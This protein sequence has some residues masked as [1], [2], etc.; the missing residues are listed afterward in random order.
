MT[1]R[2]LRVVELERRAREVGILA[3][4]HCPRFP[5]RA[6]WLE[7]LD[8]VDL[9]LHAGDLVDPGVLRDL[10]ALAPVV[11]V[12]GNN[13]DP[14]LGLPDVARVRLGELRLVLTHGHL[15]PGPTT[16]ER[17]ATLGRPWA[18]LVVFGHSHVPL[19]T[20]VDGLVLLNP[21]SASDPR[22]AGTT[23]LARLDVARRR[24]TWVALPA[25]R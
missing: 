15:G 14:A 3:D 25:V 13:D 23:G 12:A 6:A 9:I 5:F 2:E 17:A 8:G 22:R 11:A 4:T 20:T 16:A 24:I 7:G 21:G 1:R 19:L 10:E 18:D